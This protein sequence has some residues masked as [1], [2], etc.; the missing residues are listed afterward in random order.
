MNTEKKWSYYNSVETYLN[1]FRKQDELRLKAIKQYSQELKQMNEKKVG[2]P[3]KY[4]HTII[5]YLLLLLIFFR[6][7]LKEVIAY[8]IHHNLLTK[9][10]NFRTLSYR[11]RFL[12]IAEY[13]EELLSHIKNN[14]FIAI[15]IDATGFSK[16]EINIWFEEKHK[17]RK[18]RSWM[19]VEIIAD[20]K[21]KK[22]IYHK[23][24]EGNKVNEGSHS[25]FKRTINNIIKKGYNVKVLYADALYDIVS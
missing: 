7:S 13:Q 5:L 9:I 15:S 2:K 24:Y 6:F 11:I 3:Y 21:T 17:I 20:I 23:V 14:R 1:K 19:K 18:K 25:K 8:V 22:I 16:N 12:P 4:T 10:P